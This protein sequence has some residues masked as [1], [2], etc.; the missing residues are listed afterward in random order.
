MYGI[1]KPDI[2]P[3][4]THLSFIIPNSASTK[5]DHTRV[6]N[7]MVRTDHSNLRNFQRRVYDRGI[8]REVS[9]KLDKEAT[10]A[11][12]R[13]KMDSN[14]LLT[15]SIKAEKLENEKENDNIA[16]EYKDAGVDLSVDN[17]EVYDVK[18][19]QTDNQLLSE[20][21][22]KYKLPVNK[23]DGTLAISNSRPTTDLPLAIKN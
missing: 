14:V 13:K 16:K 18:T 15:H 10:F 5:Q 4:N 2:G 8:I 22:I 12:K 6:C 1:R 11:S 7:T 3:N 19:P 20:L 17:S 23:N 21:A 9:N